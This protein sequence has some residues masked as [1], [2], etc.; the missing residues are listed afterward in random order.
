ML[1][2]FDWKPAGGLKPE[3]LDM[4]ESFGGAVK[5]KQDLKLIPISYRSLVG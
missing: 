4:T 3:N 1:Y 5:R 2:H